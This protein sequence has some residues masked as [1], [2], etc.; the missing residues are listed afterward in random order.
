MKF[1]RFGDMGAERPGVR[2]DDGRVPDIS[3]LVA[4]IDPSAFALGA[5]ARLDS[6][7]VMACPLVP[8]GTR[9][10]VPVARTG[11]FLAIG[12]NYVQHALETNSP[13]PE[14]PILFNNASS[15]IS[16]PHDPVLLSP[17]SQTLDWEVELA[18][19]IGTRAFRVTEGR[20]SWPSAP[21]YGVQRHLGTPASAGTR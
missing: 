18:F 14:E 8:E 6:A 1:L 3:G 12:L 4:D 20:G 15:C 13:M 11:N 7:E 9:L 5:L 17:G 16:G 2:A 10:A 21:L 19:V